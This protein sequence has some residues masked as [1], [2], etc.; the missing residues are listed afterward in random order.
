MTPSAC[1]SNVP[2]L[3]QVRCGRDNVPPTN[4]VVC[5]MMSLAQTLTIRLARD[6]AVEALSLVAVCGAVVCAGPGARRRGG[7]GR[8]PPCGADAPRG[9]VG[10]ISRAPLQRRDVEARRHGWRDYR[11]RASG[12]APPAPRARGAG[13]GRCG[14]ARNPGVLACGD[15]DRGPAPAAGLPASRRAVLVT[16][17]RDRASRFVASFVGSRLPA[18]RPSGL[19]MPTDQLKTGRRFSVSAADVPDLRPVLRR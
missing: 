8:R 9:G 14:P 17:P 11:G 7:R 5:R 4:A 15:P 18:E 3:V 10:S 16:D 19:S 6:R 1:T 13:A 12:R 2:D